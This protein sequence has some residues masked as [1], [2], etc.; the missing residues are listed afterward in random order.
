MRHS[1]QTGLRKIRNA[2]DVSDRRYAEVDDGCTATHD[3]LDLSEF[4]LCTNEADFQTFNLAEPTFPTSFVDAGKQVVADLR[5]A[6]TLSWFWPP[7]ETDVVRAAPVPR[8]C[9]QSVEREGRAATRRG[10][11]PVARRLGARSHR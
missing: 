11:R 9:S 5:E 7:L 10:R 4:L 8:R 1:R 3:L 2:G 6:L